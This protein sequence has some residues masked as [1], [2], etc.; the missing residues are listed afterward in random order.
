MEFKPIG[1]IHSP[2]KS[3]DKVPNQSKFSEKTAEIEVY[4]EFEDGLLD[5]EGFS[6]I[7]VTWVLH[8]SGGFKLITET[9]HDTKKHGVFATR[10]PNRPNS[11]AISV[12]ELMRRNGRILHIKGID[13]IEGSPV[14]D[15]K[16]YI[17][18]VDEVAE[19]RLG[20]FGAR[21]KA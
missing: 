6:H 16:P 13:A 2:Y 7:L 20:W 14:L 1:V 10:S 9:P 8:K 3:G 15:I 17:P 21:K 18:N 11:I 12:S 4:P 5:L 19:P